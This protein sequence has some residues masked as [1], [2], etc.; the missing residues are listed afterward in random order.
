MMRTVTMSS[1]LTAL[2]VLERIAR[3]Q[4]VGLSELARN[5]ALPKSTVQRCLATLHE[6]GWIEPESAESRR[7]VLAMHAFAVAVT[8]IDR[9]GLRDRALPVM[10]Q[11]GV[12][13]EE[14]IHLAIP[15][16]G[17]IVLVERIDSPHTLRTVSPVGTRSPLHASSNGKAV[18]AALS[19]EEL[20]AYLSDGLSQLT[21][22][23][24]TDEAALRENLDQARSQGYAVSREELQD[25]VVSVAAAIMARNGRP[26][27]CLSISGPRDRMPPETVRAYGPLVA[28]AAHDIGQQLSYYT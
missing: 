21:R 26:V 2:T 15:D 6:A 25:G 22:H 4:P 11:L 8:V 18:L 5:L 28:R 23:T 9:A 12:Q 3:D 24:L 10:R 14:T 17:E 20:R 27:A 19:E 1:T 13:T 7:W 16:G